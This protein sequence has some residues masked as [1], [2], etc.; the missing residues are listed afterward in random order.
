MYSNEHCLEHKLNRHIKYTNTHVKYSWFCGK[1]KYAEKHK[2][3]F[4][5][6]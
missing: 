1:K 6:Y 4:Y 5:Y 3:K 2:L